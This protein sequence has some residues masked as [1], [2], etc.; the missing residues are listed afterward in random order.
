M[1]LRRVFIGPIVLGLLFGC[2]AACG[3]DDSSSKYEAEAIAA[4]RATLAKVGTRDGDGF[5]AGFTTQ[6]F[7]DFAR[8]EWGVPSSVVSATAALD[9][10]VEHSVYFVDS[11]WVT[12]G[13]ASHVAIA[14]QEGTRDGLSQ[15]QFVLTRVRGGW[16]IDVYDPR[17]IS[18]AVP[19]GY[20]RSDVAVREYEITSY[21]GL[22]PLPASAAFTIR[23]D[24][25]FE[26]DIM[27]LW[28]SARV[29]T[30][31]FFFGVA[32]AWPPL[33]E[34]YGGIRVA[35]GETARLIPRQPLEHR[36]GR[37]VLFCTLGERGLSHAR[38]GMLLELPAQ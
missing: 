34:P 8:H 16:L 12:D 21:A 26:H 25:D 38:L 22:P 36:D 5:R 4:L 10:T 18:P 27:L 9:D 6:G 2:A 30:E 14:V 35:P 19:P 33:M 1:L 15:D 23:N 7:E 20:Q 37:Y 13:S 11:L 28:L 17:T 29:P 31:G 3:D 24:G 32:E